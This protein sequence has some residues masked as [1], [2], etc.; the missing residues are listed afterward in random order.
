MRR[1]RAA[2]V[3]SAS[4]LLVMPAAA[5][6]QRY[7]DLQSVYAMWSFVDVVA[8]LCWE[9]ADYDVAYMEAGEGW[10]ARNI[11][12][13]DEADAV[14]AGSGEPASLVAEGEKYASDTMAGSIAADDDPRAACAQWLANM[15]S[16]AYELETM[17]AQQLGRLRE[18]DGL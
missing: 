5:Q 2:V 8:N 10:K 12:V 13:R 4:V 14:L 6:S 15:N 7:S 1:F 3:V 11:F 17:L 18:R 9:I 16:G